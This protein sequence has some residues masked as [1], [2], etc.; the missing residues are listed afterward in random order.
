MVTFGSRDWRVQRLVLASWHP[1]CL[2]D[3]SMALHRIPQRDYV[4]L[5]NLKP[6][7][8]TQNRRDR[9]IDSGNV[10]ADHCNRGHALIAENLRAST[11][12]QGK[13]SC[14]SCDRA[15][16]RVTNGKR[17]KGTDQSTNLDAYA[18]EYFTAIVSEYVAKT[19]AA[20]RFA[21]A[22][23]IAATRMAATNE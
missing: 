3:G 18:D 8:Y 1:G 5:W 17:L 12:K 15:R 20:A 14:L 2:D 21:I 11:A 6:G 13:R 4:A 10:D 22:N 9:M 23:P 19:V 7:D 16:S